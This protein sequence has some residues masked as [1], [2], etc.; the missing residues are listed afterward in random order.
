MKEIKELNNVDLETKLDQ[1][2]N[3]ILEYKEETT[4]KLLIRRTFMLE[5]KNRGYTYKQ[6]AEISQLSTSYCFKEILYAERL[7]KKYACEIDN[8]N[9]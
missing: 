2:S 8:L 7:F 1:V 3:S 4:K 5:L 6:I 9:K